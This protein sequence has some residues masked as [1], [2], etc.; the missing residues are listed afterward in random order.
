[1][2]RTKLFWLLGLCLCALLAVVPAGAEAGGY[3]GT[4][5]TEFICRLNARLPL[6]YIENGQCVR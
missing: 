3:A 5:D 2:K 4:S 1:M 6:R